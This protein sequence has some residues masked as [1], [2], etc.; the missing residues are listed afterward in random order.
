MKEDLAVEVRDLHIVRGTTAIL[1]GVDCRLPAGKCTVLLGANGCG[2]TTLTRALTGHM[3]ITRGRIRV[4]GQVL[5]CTDIRALRRRVAV[6]NSTVDSAGVHVSGAVVDAD[7]S[8]L[9]VVITGFF[10]TVGLYDRPTDEQCRHAADCL[11]DVQLDHRRDLRFALLSTGEQRRCLIARALVQTPHLLILD[12]PAA[13]L[14][15]LGR[16]QV[17]DTIENLLEGPRPPTV[18]LI[19]HH[20][21]ELPRHTYQVLL[22]KKGQI[23]ASGISGKVISNESLSETFGCNVSVDRRDGRYWTKVEGR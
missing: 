13:G 2:K 21:E 15:L 9:E 20:V 23:I 7:L 14:D 16:E 19:T 12:E 6:V 10:Q 8:A 11:Q 1:R 17:L 5:G 18:F 22:M 4:L 3:L